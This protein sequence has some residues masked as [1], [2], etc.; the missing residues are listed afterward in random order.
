[1]PPNAN[2][3]PIPSNSFIKF[4]FVGASICDEVDSCVDN[5]DDA[6]ELE[7]DETTC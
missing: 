3:R 2:L 1:M 7:E 6:S 5:D 4:L